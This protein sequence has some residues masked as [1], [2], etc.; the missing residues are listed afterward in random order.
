MQTGEHWYEM[1][2]PEST[3]QGYARIQVADLED[4]AQRCLWELHLAFPGGTY[5]EERS[6]VF[7]AEGRMLETTYEDEG[8]A[9][10][11]RRH[12]FRPRHDLAVGLGILQDVRGLQRRPSS[13]RR[14]GAAATS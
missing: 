6:A 8:S 3:P 2:D 5:E 10:H 7:D 9:L 12:G 1:Q 14:T 13:F 11:A 4:G